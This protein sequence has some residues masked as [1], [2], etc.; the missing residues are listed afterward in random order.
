MNG[1]EGGHIGAGGNG[2]SEVTVT[3]TKPMA[4]VIAATALLLAVLHQDLW[5]WGDRR[6]L[7]GWLPIGLAYHAGFSLAAAALWAWAVKGA[8][9]TAIERWADETPALG[10]PVDPRTM[11]ETRQEIL[12]KDQPPSHLRDDDRT[13][14]GGDATP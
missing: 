8:W 6:L 1:R 11:A 14:K 12:P 10:T 4:W 5:F 13:T 2:V 7:F 3:K 9:P